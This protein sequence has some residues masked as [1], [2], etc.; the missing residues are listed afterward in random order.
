MAEPRKK[1]GEQKLA[2][3]GNG[4]KDEILKTGLDK[5]K[6]NFPQ[7]L[8]K[9]TKKEDPQQ[10]LKRVLDEI[11]SSD[12][13]NCYLNYTLGKGKV[14]EKI[15]ENRRK[16]FQQFRDDFRRRFEK[17]ISNGKIVDSNFEEGLIKDFSDFIQAKNE[18][19]FLVTLNE[20]L[21]KFAS[22]KR[23]ISIEKE[24]K[25]EKKAP[26]EGEF[27]RKWEGNLDGS[28]YLQGEQKIEV[29]DYDSE[30]GEVIIKKTPGE[31]VLKVEYGEFED[32]MR[33]YQLISMIPK[34]KQE[35]LV[36]GKILVDEEGRVVRIGTY[37]P[38]ERQNL[39]KGV[40]SRYTRK[41]GTVNI[42]G[43][44]ELLEK[45]PKD[46]KT[47]GVFL[48]LEEVEKFIGQLE[49][50]GFREINKIGNEIERLNF[51][52]EEEKKK[53]EEEGASTKKKKN[54]KI[55]G[56]FKFL[57][58][59]KNFSGDEINSGRIMVKIQYG[60]KVKYVSAK[61][62]KE[63]L[64]KERFLQPEREAKQE[65]SK[66][67]SEKEDEKNE[68]K[69]K[70]KEVVKR[71]KKRKAEVAEAIDE[72]KDADTEKGEKE[73]RF[74]LDE[75]D[76]DLIIGKLT[77][78][79][80]NK[81]H[82]EK[83]KKEKPVF[84]EEDEDLI[85]GKLTQEELENYRRERKKREQIDD[86]DEDLLRYTTE[87]REAEEKRR[88]V[89]GEG[90]EKTELQFEIENLE[91]EID[92][93]KEKYQKAL[94]KFKKARQGTT[95]F[96]RALSIFERGKEFFGIGDSWEG[97]IWIEKKKA[98][99]EL[100][101]ARQ[102][103]E[104]AYLKTLRKIKE[105][106]QE[107]LE[108]MGKSKEEAT[109]ALLE[110]MLSKKIFSGPVSL[111]AEG[112][113][114]EI[115]PEDQGGRKIAFFEKFNLDLAEAER[116]ANEE[117]FDQERRNI[118]RKILERYQ[119]LS[120][121]QKIAFSVLA[122]IAIGA[123]AGAAGGATVAVTAGALGGGRKL[124]TLMLGAGTSASVD[125][126]L[127]VIQK[128]NQQT[129]RRKME[130]DFFK[131]DAEEKRVL[132]YLNSL[133]E[134]NEKIKKQEV[135]RKLAAAGAAFLVGAGTQAF[136]ND[137][138]GWDMLERKGQVGYA[139]SSE[140]DAGIMS[141]G[142]GTDNF[143]DLESHHQASALG[144]IGKKGHGMETIKEA[145][146]KADNFSDLESQSQRG[147]EAS[148]ESSDAGITEKVTE[149][150][151]G[152]EKGEVV[153]S[154]VF[155]RGDTVWEKLEKHYNGDQAKVAETLGKFRKE[156]VQKM[157]TEQEI[158][159]NQAE[160]Y[161]KWRFRH[162]YAQKDVNKPLDKIIL[163]KKG[164]EESL[165]FENFDHEEYLKRFSR[166]RGVEFKKISK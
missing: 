108:K 166:E 5:I 35:K 96:Q 77:Q 145:G 43:P 28:Y 52:L 103:L 8:D 122:S 114:T 91:K 124:L 119:R 89:Y 87:E 27:W 86:M 39:G 88:L 2:K 105:A 127:K 82:R 113:E 99:L 156:I 56:Q 60:G 149:V 146:V 128:K 38:G 95:R 116:K 134:L 117:L 19:S 68:A 14:S 110:L 71:K 152:K 76:E 66:E 73:N 69:K 153:L 120:R 165:V 147:L 151:G 126:L 129:I 136:L 42:Q 130:E 81:H 46:E 44:E 75:E 161:L 32:L 97:T 10:R 84:D 154:E 23:V 48:T 45:F 41:E 29:V 162:I 57:V 101:A 148:Q 7:K 159:P 63:I 140:T 137:A 109:V 16:K 53:L 100:K 132:D 51:W 3:A 61:E 106:S 142:I 21:E 74:E 25:K 64:E 1:I 135:Q 34:E 94:V 26:S 144:G 155:K 83:T 6:P 139:A 55:L 62:L 115:N 67:E 17:R 158:T 125:N 30:K 112:A 20:S 13:E 58:K 141:K 65:T 98:E 163:V 80:L 92:Q 47:R 138:L 18:P 9:K 22:R 24:N 11:F 157:V 150:L 36:V 40:K 37:K 118:F 164:N 70:E 49:K 78:E 33:G 79:E 102:E 90:H 12:A 123:G 4:L 131:G 85:I 143:S 50:R 111:G 93:K 133:L 104:E 59:G 121:K 54:L 72:K 160:E 15:K 31:K 107:E